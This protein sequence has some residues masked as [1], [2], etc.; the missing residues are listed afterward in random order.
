MPL[1]MSLEYL[2]IGFIS[3]DVGKNL[4]NEV[5][6]GNI[7]PQQYQPEIS[8]D[9]DGDKLFFKYDK[10]NNESNNKS[11]YGD[12]YKSYYQDKKVAVVSLKSYNSEYKEEEKIPQLTDESNQATPI[13]GKKYSFNSSKS[14]AKVI[15]LKP[16]KSER[17]SN[18][19]GSF[20]LHKG[21]GFQSVNTISSS[22]PYASNK[23][24]M[25]QF[26]GK[27]VR[28]VSELM[29][30][31]PHPKVFSVLFSIKTT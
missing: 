14:N 11:S 4:Q 13:A 3:E 29:P 6:S 9:A 1:L 18:K 16:P 26:M 22:S 31:P 27:A 24:E 30:Q 21:Q 28:K 5:A 25:Q 8:E 10:S 17:E 19:N 23:E 2:G 12:L 7:L 20:M 15:A